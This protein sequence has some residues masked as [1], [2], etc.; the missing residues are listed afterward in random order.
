META[1]GYIYNMDESR[2]R[3]L[4]DNGNGVE[5]KRMNT[6]HQNSQPL[7]KLL[8]PNYVAGALIGKGGTLM[9]EMKEKYG[10]NIRLSANGEVYP[11][12]D[13]RIIVLTGELHEINELNNAIMEK[14]Q[15]VTT[16]LPVDEARREKAKFVLTNSSAG[17]LIGRGGTTIKAIHDE[18]KAKISICNTDVATVPGERVLT[19]SGNMDQRVEASRLIIEK[20]STDLTNINNTVL[21]YT[22]ARFPAVAD[23]SLGMPPKQERGIVFNNN[24]GLSYTNQQENSLPMMNGRKSLKTKVEVTI[25]VPQILVGPFMGKSGQFIR[26]MAQQSGARFKFSDKNE[27]AEGTTDRILTITTNTIKQ[28]QTAY[29]LVHERIDVVQSQ[30]QSLHNAHQRPLE[31]NDGFAYNA[32]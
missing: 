2:K 28:A 14:I 32:Y 6:G 7:L 11:G 27:Y 21:K 3:Q 23:I 26:E 5:V 1:T 17:L 8:V 31:S 25:E 24:V 18:S 30:Q 15:D 9:K 12:T 16:R 19:L 29:C 4:Q 20:I 13:E 22:S 10:G